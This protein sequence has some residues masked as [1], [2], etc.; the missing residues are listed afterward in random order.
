MLQ[1][2]AWA[3]AA[4]PWSANFNLLAM[5][6]SKGGMQNMENWKPLMSNTPPPPPP[7][8]VEFHNHHQYLKQR[9]Q[10]SY[11]TLI[12]TCH[13]KGKIYILAPPTKKKMIVIDYVGN[14]LNPLWPSDAIWRHRYW[15]TLAQVMACC[16]TAPSLYLNQCWLTI[17]TDQWHL[18]KGNFPRDTPA[19]NHENQLQ[20]A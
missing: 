15:S 4:Q 9:S 14:L 10:A 3:G 6:F 19:I 12:D 16:L 7:S 11:L 18:S 20:F 8:S 17:S 5:V 1:S 2:V 13:M